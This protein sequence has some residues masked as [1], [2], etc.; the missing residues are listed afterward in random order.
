MVEKESLQIDILTLFPSFFEG[1]FQESLLKKAR[2][3]GLLEVAVHDL[4]DYTHDRHKTAD[5]KPFGGGPG[6]VMKPEPVFE[7]VDALRRKGD[8]GWVIVMDPKGDVFNQKMARKLARKKRLILIAGHYE[9]IDHRVSEGL[10]DQAVSV[11]DFITMGGEAPALCVIE[12]VARLIPGVVGNKASLVDES[13]EMGGLE[14]PQYT[15]PREFRGMKVPDVLISGNH[16]EVG[17]WRLKMAG[18]A[19]KSE[20]PD[21]IKKIAGHSRK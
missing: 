16:A 4:R 9:G 17:A 13:F 11:G 21:L 20:R 12:A 2:D 3:K 14:Y 19:T 1:P 5:D 6:M 15:R 7:C 10:A 8:K 18:Q